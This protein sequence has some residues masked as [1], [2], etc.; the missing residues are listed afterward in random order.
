MFS[1]SF[2][3]VRLNL[4]SY[5][6]FDALQAVFMI[7]PG[8]AQSVNQAR[9]EKTA[10]LLRPGGKASLQDAGGRSY[11]RRAT[12]LKFS[13]KQYPCLRASMY[14]EMKLSVSERLALTQPLKH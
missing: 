3:Q 1:S 11:M 12:S 4:S 6:R 7:V 5:V 2:Q 13:L 8:P 14:F 10:Q 9:K